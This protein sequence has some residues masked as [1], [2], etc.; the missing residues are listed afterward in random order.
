MVFSKFDLRLGYYYLK[1]QSKDIPKTNFRTWYGHHEFLVMSFGLIN[2]PK[3]FM[4]LM[5]N[6]FKFFLYSFFYSIY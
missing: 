4:S 3:T 6:I 1:M 2:A 5:N